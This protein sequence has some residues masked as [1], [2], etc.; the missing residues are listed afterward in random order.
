VIVTKFGTPV[1]PVTRQNL[2]GEPTPASIR[3]SIE[4]SRKNLRR[5]RIDIVLFHINEYPADTAEFVFDTLG[6]LRNEGKIAAFGWSTDNVDSAR[7]FAD[8]DGFVAVENDLNVFD[9]ADALMAFV[10]Q[11]GC[12]RSTACHWPWDCSRANT[13][14]ANR[15]GPTTSG[16]RRC[17]G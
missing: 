3:A 17:T 16:P 2:G 1:D 12:C 8:R 11:K 4:Q 15:S 14:R 10:E 7:A 9:H 5:D 6:H 13:A